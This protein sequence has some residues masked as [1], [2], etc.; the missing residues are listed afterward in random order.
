MFPNPEFIHGI[1]YIGKEQD[2][3]ILP[4]SIDICRKNLKEV[5]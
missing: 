1:S 4:P 5:T 2:I 3:D